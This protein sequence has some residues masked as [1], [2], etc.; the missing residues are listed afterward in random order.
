MRLVAV[1]AKELRYAIELTPAG[2]LREENGVVLELPAEWSAEHLLL[3]AL[4][5][6]SLTS[7]RYNAQR[8]GID[9]RSASARGRALVTRRE[10]DE[11]YAVVESEVE[12]AMELDPEPEPNALVE[13]LAAAEH[14]CFIGSS[15]TAAPSY[16]WRVNGRTIAS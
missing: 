6:C 4:V 2:E 11:R 7:L 12:L 16:R 13:L 8:R 3:A 15:L 9:V 5:R 14:E 10:E 1:R